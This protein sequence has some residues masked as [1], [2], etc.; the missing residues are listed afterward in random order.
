MVIVPNGRPCPCGQAGCFERYASA[1]AVAQRAIEAMKSGEES[2][3]SEVIGAGKPIDAESVANAARDGDALAARI[4]DETCMYLA[5]G[6]VN[7]EHLLAPEMIVLAG[8]L[9]QAGDQLLFPMRAHF[10]RLRWKIQTTPPGIE[11]AT[12]STDAGIIG[13]AMLARQNG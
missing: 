7:L 11:F 2:T 4:W 3:L 10:T 12:L 13:A 5:L 8:G 9:I 1:S 6:C